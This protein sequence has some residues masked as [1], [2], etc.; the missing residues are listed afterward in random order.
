MRM[1]FRFM[2]QC[3]LVSLA[4]ILM[5][6]CSATPT[7]TSGTTKANT[8]TSTTTSGTTTSTTSAA[9]DWTTNIN[10]E[11]TWPI[12]NEPIDVEIAFVPSSDKF[13]ITKNWM[14]EFMNRS[15][16]LNFTWTFISPTS[17]NE[18]VSLM[19]NSG[20]LPDAIQGYNF[21]TS[22]IVQYGVS[23]GL[24]RPINDLLKYCPEFSRFIEED[25]SILTDITAT[26]G[27]VY[28]LPAINNI[29]SYNMRM[30]INGKWLERVGVSN[31][32]TLDELYNML[33]AFRD[34]D[35]NGN[36]D[37]T[38]EIPWSGAWSEGGSERH[39]ILS[40]YGYITK[41]ANNVVVDYSAVDSGGKEKI[42]YVGYTDQYKEYLQYMKKLWDEN[43]L[44][45]DMFTQAETQ[46]QATVLEG[47]VGLCYMS[48]PYV[49]DPDNQDDYT[50][51][52]GIVDQPGDTPRIPVTGK[53]YNTSR[54][55][56]N[57]DI[58]DEKAAALLN[59][60]DAYYS[61][62]GWAYAT[63][64]P[65][66]GSDLDWFEWGHFYNEE[67]NNI[68]YKL[69]PDATGAWDHRITYL[70]FYSLP[71]C[72]STGY[73]PYRV[74]YAEVYP[75]SAIGKFYKDGVKVRLDE[76]VQQENQAPYYADSVPD[77]FMTIDDLNRINELITPLDDYMK[78]ME[79]Q[80]IVGDI[81]IDTEFD[82][83]ITTLKQY[84]VEELIEIYNKYFDAYQANKG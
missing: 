40:A 83:F 34:G 21:S 7:T 82:N 80:F 65:E 3:L 74:K 22:D 67:T 33:I 39:L 25:P 77:F 72:N 15:C 46:V 37:A 17:S 6:S 79:A 44:D 10:L 54:F 48:A 81:S 20:E 28:G 52:T 43:L 5:T 14:V 55:A 78:S 36:G 53:V 32:T 60:A 50:C 57:A 11:S 66:A 38:D 42:N 49:Y 59:Y 51:T 68:D 30:F 29:W 62:E 8:T 2:I 35:A 56:V 12:V 27:N 18:R 24:F 76:K 84:G 61:L 75:N 63:F 23:E 9:D 69:N 4:L 71:G 19:L 58:E 70:T 73:D 16:N 1:K 26:D 47:V 64:G 45:R 31:P 13:D 41:S